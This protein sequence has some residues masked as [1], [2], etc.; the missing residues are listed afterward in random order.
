MTG[1]CV[2][3]SRGMQTKGTSGE[4]AAKTPVLAVSYQI[5]KAQ[6]GDDRKVGPLEMEGFGSYVTASPK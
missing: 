5:F 6:E 3:F 2:E 4:S 1:P